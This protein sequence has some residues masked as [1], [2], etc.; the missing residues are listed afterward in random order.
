MYIGC[1][2][3]FLVRC[4]N[5]KDQCVI[6]ENDDIVIIGKKTYKLNYKNDCIVKLSVMF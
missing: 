2:K 5:I 3:F 6:L 4:D 1:L